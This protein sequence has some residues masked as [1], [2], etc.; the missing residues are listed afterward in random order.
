MKVVCYFKEPASY[1]LALKKEVYDPLLIDARFLESTSLA[2][3]NEVKALSNLSIIN[4]NK[5]LWSDSK[6]YEA[7]IF[8]GFYQKELFLLLFFSWLQSNPLKVALDSDTPLNIPANPFKRMVK[9]ILLNRL[10]KNKRIYGLAGGSGSHKELFR[11]YGMKDNHIVLL[12]M[13]INVNE[14]QGKERKREAQFEFLYVGRIE[15]HKNIRYL[16]E[17]FREVFGNADSIRLKIVGGGSELAAFEKDFPDSNITFTGKLFDNKLKQAYKNASVLV[18]PS[19]F[20]PWGLVVNEAMA[21]GLPVISSRFVGANY[22]LIEGKGTGLIFDPEKEGDL[23][24]KMLEMY[25]D[26]IQYE[27]FS[28]NAY[29]L[30][31]NYW[32][33]DLYK[34]QLLLAIEKMKNA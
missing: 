10:F 19:L 25:C 23:K 28:E 21:S 9:K 5:Q 26:K 30:M 20:E 7:A 11:Y 31:H 24:E 15:M 29:N 8:N 4:K 6:H 1:T 2:S 16:L 17:T 22:D 34:K 14:F 13:V 12:P 33:Y 18:L 27:K 3:N 32:N